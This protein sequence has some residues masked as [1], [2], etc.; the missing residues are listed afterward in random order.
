MIFFR[1]ICMALV[2]VVMTVSI[3]S[4][5]GLMQTARADDAASADDWPA[6]IDYP[7]GVYQDPTGAKA[8]QILKTWPRQSE[9]DR[10][11]LEAKYARKKWWPFGKNKEEAR[12]GPPPT[13]DQIVEVGP[14]DTKPVND[15]LLPLSV[16]L[17]AP[18]SPGGVE[19]GFYLI[20]Q[21]IVSATQRD[22]TLIKKNQPVCTLSL[23]KISGDNDKAP[24]VAADPKQP[25][26]N[27]VTLG[28]DVSVDGQHV[29]IYLQD[30]QERYQSS[31]LPTRV[32]TRQ[33]MHY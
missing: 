30:G 13:E 33:P 19:S 16:P 22:I 26:R 24:V 1:S 15:P 4:Q 10:K 6:S 2:L 12:K 28:S 17:Q 25:T 27:R 18:D 3:V 31:P 8:E 32:D 29:V 7:P 20:H 23:Y 11:K 14:R 21:K 5:V 9:I